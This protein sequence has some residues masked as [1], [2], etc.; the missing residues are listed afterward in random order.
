MHPVDTYPKDINELDS[1]C[2]K[3]EKLKAID[4]QVAVLESQLDARKHSEQEQKAQ[5]KVLEKTVKF[6]SALDGQVSANE[7]VR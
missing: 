3:F 4:K 2:D 5:Q 7:T 6:R 1:L